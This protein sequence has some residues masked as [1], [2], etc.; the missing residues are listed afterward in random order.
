MMSGSRRQSRTA[1]VG[2]VK[3]TLAGMGSKEEDAP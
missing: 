3:R 1:V 2:F